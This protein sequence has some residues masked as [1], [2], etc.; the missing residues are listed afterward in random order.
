MFQPV[1]CLRLLSAKMVILYTGISSGTLTM[2]IEVHFINDDE[3]GILDS[4]FSVCMGRLNFGLV[5]CLAVV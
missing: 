4:R 1:R 3:I 5:S 2:I